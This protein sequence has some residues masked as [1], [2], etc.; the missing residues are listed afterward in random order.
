MQAAAEGFLLDLPLSR[1]ARL[2][3]WTV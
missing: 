2:S 3:R 1:T